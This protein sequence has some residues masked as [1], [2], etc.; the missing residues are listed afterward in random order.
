MCQTS[1]TYIRAA[2]LLATLM[3][4]LPLF[5]ED[6]ASAALRGLFGGNITSLIT[7]GSGSDSIMGSTV[8][9]MVGVV[10]GIVSTVALALLAVALLR[11][12]I[13]SAQS[14]KFLAGEQ[15]DS[16]WFVARAVLAA[17]LL[18]PLP[19]GVAT[20][21]VMVL[22]LAQKGSDA[23]S[24][25]LAISK[26]AKVGD[27]MFSPSA[28]IPPPTT[29]G[30]Q[31][32]AVKNQV[33]SMVDMVLAAEAQDSIAMRQLRV[34]KDRWDYDQKAAT[35]AGLPVPPS[36]ADANQRA[37]VAQVQENDKGFTIGFRP[38]APINTDPSRI[39]Q[40]GAGYSFPYISS[41]PADRAYQ[42]AEILKLVKAVDG[43]RVQTKQQADL[44]QVLSSDW[45]QRRETLIDDATF[46][47]LQALDAIILRSH[48]RA[49]QKYQTAYENG[50]FWQDL[51]VSST[52][53]G[54]APAAATETTLGKASTVP[55]R[56]V[57]NDWIGLGG[58][59]MASHAAVMQT[60]ANLITNVLNDA[61]NA[62]SDVG[63]GIMQGIKVF[64][65]T[66]PIELVMSG[67][68][69][70]KNLADP[71]YVQR[72]AYSSFKSLALSAQRTLAAGGN[73]MALMQATGQ[74]L[75]DTMSAAWLAMATMR[76]IADAFAVA[77]QSQSVVTAVASVTPIVGAI[78]G[79]AAS[80][81]NS[82]MDI[83]R[84]LAMGGYLAG[85]GLAL[86]IPA[87]PFIIWLGMV[88]AWLVAVCE[89][90]IGV[91]PWSVMHLIG[92]E[93]T[94]FPS[95]THSGYS[96]LFALLLRPA[97]YVLSFHFAAAIFLITAGLAN[98][99]FPHFADTIAFDSLT[100]IVWTICLLI[101]FFALM[102][103]VTHKSFEAAPVIADRMLRWIGADS[104][105]FNSE[106]RAHA[107]F[108]GGVSRM[109]GG[110]SPRGGGGFRPAQQPSSGKGK[111][112]SG[113]GGQ[114]GG[115]SGGSGNDGGG[116]RDGGLQAAD[117]VAPDASS[118]PGASN[119][120]SSNRGG[121]GSGR[122]DARSGSVQ[123][124]SSVPR[125]SGTTSVASNIGGTHGRPSNHGGDV[126][127]ASAGG[128]DATY[129]GQY[130]YT[131]SQGASS[132]PAAPAGANSPTASRTSGGSSSISSINVQSADS[133]RD[134]VASA[135]SG[136][137]GKRQS[138]STPL[139]DRSGEGDG[140]QG[141]K[142]PH[143]T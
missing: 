75:V 87:V 32:A 16:V 107:M 6:T 110:R 108:A 101:L 43:I 74:A 65:T 142:R 51:T 124:G 80:F 93:Q 112:G 122:S 85:F 53:P 58:V 5:A 3:V 17:M 18:L 48:A 56:S 103:V 131:S 2:S 41:L 35:E 8:S 91:V 106:G 69:R 26:A 70:L 4:S 19:S 73:P 98:A 37:Q 14:G 54:T 89:A 25:I 9:K 30:V 140:V 63:S 138:F 55:A 125:S 46:N 97:V 36:P 105:T 11:R 64:L 24:G 39:M 10:V 109:Y 81:I 139:F 111:G 104:P 44:G 136:S 119:G 13:L 68:E 77:T 49:V 96:M 94:L 128:A 42:R 27:A 60:K 45:Q 67:I 21:Q 78:A 118:S 79:G 132:V 100:S 34:E 137:D 120:G 40:N 83:F 126:Q 57:P 141:A 66:S 20:S 12:L 62:A 86:Y 116:K 113:G 92:D 28:N 123:G 114:P 15:G 1:R 130:G 33:S 23:A 38:A 127:A 117:G 115:G 135:G 50:D 84:P 22:W 29:M 82:L 7:G 102:V 90:F 143:E 71:K 52:I 133:S 76:A 95:R 59:Y 72:E 31:K 61:G 47:Y 121:S 99:A 134:G 88:V 129:A